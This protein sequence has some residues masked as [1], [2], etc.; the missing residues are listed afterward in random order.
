MTHAPQMAFMNLTNMVR[1]DM[2]MSFHSYEVQKQE[3]S[4][5]IV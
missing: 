4:N 1:S 5:H 2:G 3:K